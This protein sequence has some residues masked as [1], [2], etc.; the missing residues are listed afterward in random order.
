VLVQAEQL[1]ADPYLPA[2]VVPERQVAAV[3]REAARNGA[4]AGDDRR[5]RLVG[6]GAGAEQQAARGRA[7]GALTI[8]RRLTT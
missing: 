1:A 7:D 4:G 6:P 8:V 3:D 5:D 2:R